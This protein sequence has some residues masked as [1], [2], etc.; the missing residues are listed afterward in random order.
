M[1]KS[2]KADGESTEVFKGHRGSTAQKKGQQGAHHTYLLEEVRTFTRLINYSFKDDELCKAYV[3]ME[4]N[5][6]DVF[7]VL[8]DGILLCK[9]INLAVPDTIDMRVVN[10]GQNLSIFKVRENL[11]LACAACSGIGLKMVGIDAASFLDKKEHLILSVLWQLLKLVSTKSVS[12][13]ECPE[14]YRLLGE[15]ETLESLAKLT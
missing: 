9:L 15:D 2:L 12:L 6:D 11:N 5:A 14:I 10:K 8:E 13:K 3:P 4:P 1:F 7:H